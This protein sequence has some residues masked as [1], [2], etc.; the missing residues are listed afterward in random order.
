[1]DLRFRPL[2]LVAELRE[3]AER[4]ADDLNDGM[5]AVAAKIGIPAA[6]PSETIEFEAAEL[7]QEMFDALTRIHAGEGDPKQIAWEIIDPN[8]PMQS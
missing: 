4:V 8:R 7:I 3:K 1:M 6:D 5:P 2:D